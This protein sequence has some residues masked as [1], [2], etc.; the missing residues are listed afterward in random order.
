MFIFR[1]N[2]Y[3]S[4]IILIKSVQFQTFMM[5]LSVSLGG[6]AFIVGKIGEYEVDRLGNSPEDIKSFV[7]LML[8]HWPKY[9][10]HTNNYHL[11]VRPYKF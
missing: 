6:W 5:D 9:N 1:P 2:Y 4:N 3:Y 10:F 11:A 8:E 7:E